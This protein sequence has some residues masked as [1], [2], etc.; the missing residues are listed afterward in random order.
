VSMTIKC[1][2]QNGG[3]GIL[4]HEQLCPRELVNLNFDNGISSTPM[5]VLILDATIRSSEPS[6]W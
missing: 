5:V 2:V 6:F 4:D 3:K 1:S